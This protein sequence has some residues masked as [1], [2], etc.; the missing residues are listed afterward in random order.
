RY[1]RR[2]RARAGRGGWGRPHR[3]ILS[4]PQLLAARDRA[5]LPGSNRSDHGPSLSCRRLEPLPRG[6]LS[7]TT[8]GFE[9]GYAAVQHMSF[10]AQ[11]WREVSRHLELNESVRRIA[12]MLAE[13]LPV[14]QVIVRRLDRDPLRLLSVASA[15]AHSDDGSESVATRSECDPAI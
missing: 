14:R 3:R 11:L 4:A 12:P 8:M 6:S 10:L 2:S 13:H 9:S 5:R 1:L 15:F 7:V